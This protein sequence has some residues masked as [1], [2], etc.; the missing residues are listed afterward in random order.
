[1]EELMERASLPVEEFEEDDHLVVRAEMPGIDPD[2]DVDI[3]ISDHMIKI[4]AERRQ[5]Q[6]TEDKRG[7]R[8][9]FNYGSF[10]RTLELPAGATEEDIEAVYRDGILEVRVPIDKSQRE[11]KK[12]AV[13]RN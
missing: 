6:R 4:K 7:Y 1:M 8:T 9:E 12:I 13:S 3:T 5:E 10:I 11:A 2:N